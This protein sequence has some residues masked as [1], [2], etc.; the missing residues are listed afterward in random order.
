MSA[1]GLV[2]KMEGSHRLG[3]AT[4]GLDD[5]VVGARSRHRVEHRRSNVRFPQRDTLLVFHIG[6]FITSRV[7]VEVRERVAQIARPAR[8]PRSRQVRPAPLQL[9]PSRSPLRPGPFDS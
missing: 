2:K 4:A 6:S 8:P 5:L 7:P 1:Q 9:S 3:N